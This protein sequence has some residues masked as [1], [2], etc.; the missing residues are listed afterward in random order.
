M[1]KIIWLVLVAVFLSCLLAG[2]SSHKS[3]LKREEDKVLQYQGSPG[4]VSFPE[5]AEDL[6]Y[7]GDLKLEYIGDSMGGLKV[8]N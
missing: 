1:K 5:L 8:S 4:I 6:G 2:C 3:M 7:L